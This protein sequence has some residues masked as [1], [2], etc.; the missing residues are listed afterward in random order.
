MS[1]G[2][3]LPERN[4]DK[5]DLAVEFDQASIERFSRLLRDGLMEAAAIHEGAVQNN[6][7][8][9]ATTTISLRTS[10]DQD[11]SKPGEAVQV[12]AEAEIRMRMKSNKE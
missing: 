2:E 3:K 11:T 8:L 4:A 10:D 6:V 9:S 12:T 5:P 1:A 7:A